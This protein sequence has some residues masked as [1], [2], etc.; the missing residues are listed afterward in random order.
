MKQEGDMQEEVQPL[1]ILSDIV[2]FNKFAKYRPDLGRRENWLEL[3]ER[4]MNMHIKKFP[5]L[6]EE[7]KNVYQK[8]VI[9]KKILPSMRSYQFAG[10]PIELANNRL[11]NCAYTA[12]DDYRVFSEIMFL[13]LGGSGVGFSVQKHHIEKLP[14]IRKPIKKRRFLVADLLKDG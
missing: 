10:K 4:N 9:P 3:N 1:K 8:F 12:C 5:Q 6:E 2:I 13:L 11:F 7:I 14:E